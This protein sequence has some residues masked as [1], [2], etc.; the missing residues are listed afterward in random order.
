MLKT[1]ENKSITI[2]TVTGSAD[3]MLNS[4]ESDQHT[5]ALRIISL[6]IFGSF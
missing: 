5:G 2:F 3:M 4:L 1:F 6:H